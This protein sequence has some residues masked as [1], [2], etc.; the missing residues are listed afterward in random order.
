MSQGV[1]K[2]RINFKIYLSKFARISL[3]I[4]YLVMPPVLCKYFSAITC[5]PNTMK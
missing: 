3:K 4:Q 1:A 2:C 5:S